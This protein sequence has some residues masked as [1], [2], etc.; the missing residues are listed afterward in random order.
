VTPTP[1]LTALLSGAIHYYSNNA[2]VV[3][4]TVQLGGSAVS[5]TQTD[6]DGEYAFA[7]LLPGDYSIIPSKQGDQGVGISTLDAVYILEAISGQLLLDSNQL[8][9][10]DV[11]GNGSLSPLDASRILQI[12]SG[13][14]TRF[15]VAQTCNSDWIF[16][17]VPSPTANQMVTLPHLSTGVCQPG[18][19][20]YAPL[21]STAAHQD[22]L[23]I[24]FGDCTGN[25]MP[26]TR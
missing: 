9:A 13:A 22:F 21:T 25:W 2:P 11:T 4:V 14:I 18:S 17:P 26:T 5:T 12:K 8:L 15:D 16:I 23:A 3:G 20:G 24:L 10:A 1:T 7:N 19:I 6:A